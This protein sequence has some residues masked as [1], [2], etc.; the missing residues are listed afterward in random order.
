[1]LDVL[2]AQ[3]PAQPM[4]FWANPMFLLAMLVLFWVVIILP[5][6]RRQKRE[7]QNMLANLKRGAKV[8]TSAGIIGTIVGVKENEDEITIRSEETRLKVLKSSVIR[9]LGSDESEAVKS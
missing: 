6:S 7:Q 9:V 4:P 8:L 1:M 5:M 3:E 2:F